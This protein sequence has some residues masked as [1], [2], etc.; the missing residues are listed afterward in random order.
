MFL[1]IAETAVLF[2]II[3]RVGSGLILPPTT[4]SEYGS[5]LL[6][7]EFCGS[8]VLRLIAVEVDAT[9]LVVLHCCCC[10]GGNVAL[11]YDH[12]LLLVL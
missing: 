2:A 5:L 12:L 4:V 1:L 3:G 7:V 6:V 11:P 9:S 10:L 8:K